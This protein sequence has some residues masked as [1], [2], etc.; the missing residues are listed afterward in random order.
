MDLDSQIMKQTYIL[1]LVETLQ[2]KLEV[3]NQLLQLTKQQEEMFVSDKIKD[4]D[5]LELISLKEE[6]INNLSKLDDGFEKL[7]QSVKD[8]LITD[9]GKYV[10]E[11]TSLKDLI[12]KITDLS[13][14]LQ[15]LEKRNKTKV[16]QHF[17][18]RRKDIGTS[19]LSSTTVANYYKTMTKQHEAQ[20]YFYDKK[21]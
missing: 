13:V 18:N 15:A 20:S 8:E 14:N 16:E 7:F 9:K 2:K 21:N 17:S 5:F 1:L 10:S 3:M 4:E 19:R 12:V 6:Q 11:I